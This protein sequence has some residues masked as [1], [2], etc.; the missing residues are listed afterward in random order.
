MP[1]TR[2][3]G[4][5]TAETNKLKYGEDFYRKIGTLGGAKSRG[6]GF[7]YD[8]ELASRAGRIGGKASRRPKQEI[9]DESRAKEHKSWRERIGL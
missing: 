4:L 3:G 2:T 9:I 7:A 6:G 5:K 1:G 8:R